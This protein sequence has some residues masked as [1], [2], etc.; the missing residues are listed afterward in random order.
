MWSAPF[1]C[2]VHKKGF[3]F[4]S[5]RRHTRSIRD[6][7]SDVCSSDLFVE[8]PLCLSRQELTEIDAARAKSSGSVMVGFNRRFA[9]ASAD[10]K[11]ILAS[12]PGPKTASFRVKIGR[13]SCRERVGSSG[14]SE[15]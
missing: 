11:E 1:I 3:F 15:W 7:A 5:R 12:V 14:V 9:P 8:K 10:L 6:W 4:S 13:A 2:K